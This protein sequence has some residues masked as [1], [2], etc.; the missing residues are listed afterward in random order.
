MAQLIISEK[1]N[2]ASKLASSLGDFK[3][4]GSRIHYF[5]G[6]IGTRSAYIVPA[7]G[8]LF[9]LAESKKRQGYPT[10]EVEWV[11]TY[12]KGATFTKPYLAQFKKLA[13]EVDDIIIAT[14]YDREGEVI[15]YNILRFVFKKNYAK[16]MKFS[17]LTAPELREAYKIASASLDSGQASAGLARHHLDFFYGISLSKAATSSVSQAIGG[18]RPLSI[19]RVQGPAL[20]ILAKREK[21]I[22]AF[23]PTPYWQIFADLDLKGHPFEAL[24]QQDRFWN[25]VDAARIFEKVKNKPATVA[26]IKKESRKVLPPTPFDL[27]TLQME[28]YRCF[29]SSPKQTLAIAQRLYTA[30]LISYPRTSSQ[31]LPPSIGYSK[32]IRKLASQP[33]FTEES[34][35]VLQGKL[36]PTQ[37]KKIDSAHPAIYPT[38]ERPKSLGADELMLYDLITRRFLACFGKA[39]EREFTAVRFDIAGEPFILRGART[40]KI[41]WQRLYFPYSKTKEIELPLLKVGETNSQSTRLEDKETQP[42]KRYTPA[43]IIKELEKNN[44]GTKATRA[45][46]IDILYQRNYIV[47]QKIKVT[48]LGLA[49]VDTFGKYAPD[50]L[51]VQLTARFEEAMDKIE[52]KSISVD[53]VLNS[54]KDILAKIC[55]EFD[56]HKPEIGKELA[57]AL[58]TTEKEQR[59]LCRCLKCGKG[60]MQV[61]KSRKSGKRFLACS[62]YPECKTTWPLPQKGG[63]KVLSKKCASC[64]LPMVGIYKKG[65]RPWIIC[66]NPDCESK[67]DVKE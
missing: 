40:T 67:K 65:R 53:A 13:K 44:L 46:I 25:S 22:A 15:G 26:D 8:H 9:G 18:F 62:G 29:R 36:S 7:V 38:G 21:E 66:V 50:I 27:T 64:G 35:I 58:Q 37:G 23:K 43:S 54:A 32:I 20:A 17:T 6:K 28:A 24:H 3:K 4:V 1:P 60:D 42:P 45:N 57:S 19:G 11:P 10:F 12:E 14:D 63:L 56:A 51:S 34:N 39:G 2:A 52:D 41:E 48:K 5:K 55:T 61:I 30:A 47:D 16:R 31:K 49:V 33:R 59:V